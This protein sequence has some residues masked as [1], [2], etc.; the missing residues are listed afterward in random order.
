VVAAAVGN[1]GEQLTPHPPK[2]PSGG[3]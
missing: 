3:F 1:K 2:N